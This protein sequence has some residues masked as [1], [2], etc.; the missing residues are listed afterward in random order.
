MKEESYQCPDCQKFYKEHDRFIRE[1]PN[2]KQ[3]QELNS[4]SI[5]SFR[6]LCSK[7]KEE[8]HNQSSD[9]DIKNKAVENN[10]HISDIEIK[11]AIKELSN[12]NAYL[13]FIG[14]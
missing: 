3:Q 4:A 8:L 1:F 7:V 12:I 11:D 2:F 13:Y 9:K 5:Q 14:A 10:K 6:S